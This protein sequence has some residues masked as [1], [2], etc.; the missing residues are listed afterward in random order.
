MTFTCIAD[1]E[2]EAWDACLEGVHYFINFYMLR[3]NLEGKWPPPEAEF[4]RE[5]IR[6]SNLQIDAPWALAVGSRDQVVRY[7]EKV[8]DGA[9][10]RMTHMVCSPRHA[11]M[12]TEAAH[13]TLRYFASDIMP[14]FK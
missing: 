3:R 6:Q 4:T 11:G 9:R 2:T 1:T 12:T 14:L 5:K 13:R 8:R 7:F 10:G